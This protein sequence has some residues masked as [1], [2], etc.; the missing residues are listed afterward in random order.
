MFVIATTLALATPVGATTLLG[1]SK[2]GVPQ[3]YAAVDTSTG[4]V[5]AFGGKR[6]TGASTGVCGGGICFVT[7]TGNFPTDITASKV[8]VNTTAQS[9]V[10]DVTNAIVTAATPTSITVSVSDWKSDD[11]TSQNDVDWITVFVGR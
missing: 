3:A 9:S 7:F 10:F 11:L 6:A 1:E 2:K 8:I 5:L 4:T